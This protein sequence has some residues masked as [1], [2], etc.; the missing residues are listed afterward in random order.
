MRADGRT[1]RQRFTVYLKHAVMNCEPDAMRLCKIAFGSGRT[2]PGPTARVGLPL[3]AAWDSMELGDFVWRTSCVCKIVRKMT[4]SVEL[5]EMELV[6]DLTATDASFTYM[7]MRKVVVYYG[8][9][10]I[11]I[12]SASG[13]GGGMI[14]VDRGEVR[15]LRDVARKWREMIVA[16]R[17]TL[18]GRLAVSRIVP[19]H[20]LLR[21]AVTTRAFVTT[22]VLR[23]RTK[24]YHGALNIETCRPLRAMPGCLPAWMAITSCGK[25]GDWLNVHCRRSAVA[26][27]ARLQL[28]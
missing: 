9:P 6:D 7:P 13:A 25:P 10:P 3:A 21:R 12:D 11:R 4:S 15:M 16:S 8:E 23:L 20:R 28:H 2:A 26:R 27:C 14:Q 19:Q 24:C 5:E 18:I 22:T 1:L 17:T